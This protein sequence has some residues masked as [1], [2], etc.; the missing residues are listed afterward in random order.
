M[1]FVTSF[2]PIT[3]ATSALAKSL[4]IS[5]NSNTSSYGTFASANKT[6]ICPGIRPATGCIAYETLISFF[7]KVSTISLKACCACATAI[8]YPGTIITDEAFFIKKAASSAFPLF[9]DLCS[10]YC[11]ETDCSVAPNP[12]KITLKNDLFIP[13]HIMY[14]RIA[15]YEPTNAPVIIKAVFSKVKPIPA[16]AQPEYEFSIEIT[17]GIS[18]PPIGII[19]KKPIKKETTN[20]IQNKFEDWVEQSR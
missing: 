9:T 8:P 3:N 6:F 7:F 1:G 12:P 11:V 15:P 18:A 13:L 19:N 4:L 17:T 10:L 20:N 14:E 16:A 5:S 2:A